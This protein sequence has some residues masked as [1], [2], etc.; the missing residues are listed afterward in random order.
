MAANKEVITAK[1]REIAEHKRSHMEAL[2]IQRLSYEEK[3][4]ARKKAL[5]EVQKKIS[6]KIC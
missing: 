5:E 6:W 4:A 2:E 3:H 1:D